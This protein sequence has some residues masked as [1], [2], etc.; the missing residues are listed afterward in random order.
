MHVALPPRERLI[1]DAVTLLEGVFIRGEGVL[2]LFDGDALVRLMMAKKMALERNDR[3]FDQTILQIGKLCDEKGQR[4]VDAACRYFHK[5]IDYFHL[6]EE[7]L[8]RINDLVFLDSRTITTAMIMA[9]HKQMHLINGIDATLFARLFED[10]FMAN[11]LIGSYGRRKAGILFKGL[12][13]ITAGSKTVVDVVRRLEFLQNEERNLMFVVEQIRDRIMN[14]YARF[15][16]KG[17]L[18]GL[19]REVTVEMRHQRLL[20][21]E[22]S[23]EIF[24]QGVAIIKKE[25]I[26]VNNIL[27][28]ILREKNRQ[29][30][31]EFL[32]E[33]GLDLF[34]VEERE[35]SYCDAHGLS[36]SL[37]AAIRQ[38]GNS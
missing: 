26:Y 30:R 8:A 7:M 2:D 23:D 16:A 18:D 35:N 4:R 5:L 10:D 12:A 29:L 9:L 27:P 1:S 21:G 33:S 20:D 14:N 15:A 32:A 3:R 19:K 38:N 17:E 25:A 6:Y 31:D 34:F 24:R 13:G 37:L 11:S 36:R 28:V 22:I